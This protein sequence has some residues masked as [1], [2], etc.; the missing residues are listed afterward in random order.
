MFMPS[1]VVAAASQLVTNILTA[2]SAG[3]LNGYAAGFLGTLVPDTFNGFTIDQ[4]A[5]STTTD[6][7]AYRLLGTN[8]PNDDN[9][10]VSMRLKGVFSSGVQDRI[11]LRTDAVYSTVAPGATTW[12]W[13]NVTDEFVLNNE[14]DVL[15]K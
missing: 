15:M 10:F 5:Q 4:L 13:I 11:Y 8:I 14:Y 7:I 2:G 9:A 3:A 12:T 1:G 6:E